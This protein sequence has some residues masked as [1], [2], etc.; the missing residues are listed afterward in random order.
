MAREDKTTNEKTRKQE[1]RQD[2]TRLTKNPP[3]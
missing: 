2:K 3:K 1:G